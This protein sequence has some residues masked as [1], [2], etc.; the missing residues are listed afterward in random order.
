[1]SG[2]YGTFL[3][4]FSELMEKINVWTKDDRSDSRDIIAAYLP[5]GGDTLKRRKYT[6]GNTALDITGE[7]CLYVYASYMN[8]IAIGDYCTLCR[9][10]LN[11]LR[12]TG[13]LPF[14]KTAG[15]LIYTVQKVTG[16]TPD[17][18]KQLE[19]K[20]GYFA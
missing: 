3:E 12:I 18:D 6:S 8:K 20:E 16:A 19:V 14:D 5:S 2:V 1:M 7:D 13:K 10:P 4:A 17:K 15:Y 9:D 11:I